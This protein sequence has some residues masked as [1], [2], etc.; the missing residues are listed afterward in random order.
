MVSAYWL[1]EIIND[2][3]A[4]VLHLQVLMVQLLVVAAAAAA[5]ADDDADGD[6][7]ASSLADGKI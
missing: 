4:G 7:D 6:V 5:A 3:P 1:T 2:R